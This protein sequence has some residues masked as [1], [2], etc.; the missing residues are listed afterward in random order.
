MLP[1]WLDTTNRSDTISILTRLNWGNYFMNRF[2]RATFVLFLLLDVMLEAS[3]RLGDDDDV[4]LIPRPLSLWWND[5]DSCGFCD[6]PFEG[7][8]PAFSVQMSGYF[9]LCPNITAPLGEK[10]WGLQRRSR[11]EQS[12]KNFVGRRSCTRSHCMLLISPHWQSSKAL[13]RIRQCMFPHNVWRLSSLSD[14]FLPIVFS[15]SWMTG[16]LAARRSSP[17]GNSVHR[18]HSLELLSCGAKY[19]CTLCE[20]TIVSAG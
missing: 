13:S 9:T 7:I 12:A 6:C 18:A 17:F 8:D 3:A 15:R 5:G 16:M 4:M 14:S 10:C 1:G 20:S 19:I 11:Q 2:S